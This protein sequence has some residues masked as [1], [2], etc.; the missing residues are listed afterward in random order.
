MSLCLHASSTTF[1]VTPV[2]KL[3]PVLRVNLTEVTLNFPNVADG[4]CADESEN[5]GCVDE[6]VVSSEEGGRAER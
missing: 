4:R 3:L 6:H 2:Q 1:R 5:E